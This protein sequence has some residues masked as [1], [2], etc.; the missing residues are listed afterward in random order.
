MKA[1]PS[2]S[3]FYFIL[4]PSSFILSKS[5][6]LD[7]ADPVVGVEAASGEVRDQIEDLI[8]EAADVEDVR[9]FG[10]LRRAVGLHVNA[11]Q[12]RARVAPLEDRP[13]AHRL[14]A[15]ARAGVHPGLVV[16]DVKDEAAP[17]LALVQA[18]ARRATVRAA[19]ADRGP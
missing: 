11:D 9:R 8:G 15:A 19:A 5:D 17:G 18:P 12:T 3:R 4:H 16:R 6:L 1:H 10:C 14:G 13:L 7:D 2:A